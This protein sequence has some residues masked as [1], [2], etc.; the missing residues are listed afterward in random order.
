MLDIE[1]EYEIGG[2]IIKKIAL[3][4]WYRG[5]RV[6]FLAKKYGFE[7]TLIERSKS[8][9]KGGYAIDLRNSC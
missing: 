7:P 8:L 9:R 5:T 1:Y 6:V 4:G 3:L 2:K